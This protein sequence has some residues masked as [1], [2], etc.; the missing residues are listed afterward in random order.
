MSTAYE[1]L[2]EGVLEAGIQVDAIGLQSHMHQGYWGE[3]KT[4]RHP[5]P[6]RA[7]RAAAAP[8][9][10]DAAVRATSCPRTSRTSTTTRSPRGRRRPRARRGRPTRS[11]GTTGPC[12]GHPAVQA[13]TYWGITD[14]GAWLG[15]PAG[16]VRADGTPKPA[17]DALR[18]LVKD[19]WWLPPTTLRTSSTGRVPVSGFRGTYSRGRGAVRA[20][21]RR[22]GRRPAGRMTG[23]PSPPSSPSPTPPTSASPTTSRLTDV[24]LR[25]R[26]EPAEGLYIAESSTVISARARGRPPAAVGAAVPRW[27]PDLE[28]LLAGLPADDTVV[29]VY[30]AEERR[31]RGD[32]RVPPA[33]RGARRDAPAGAASRSPGA[34]RRRTAAGRRPGG[35]R[36]P[37]QRRRRL[38]LRGRARAS[39][40]CSSPRAAPTRSTGG[41]SGSRWGPCSR[42]RGRGIDPWPDGIDVLRE[43]GLHR[44]ALALSDDSITLDDLVAD[45]P[46]RLALVLGA[47]GHGLKPA[48]VGRVRPGGADPDGR[49]G[50]L[51]QRRRGRAVAFW[52]TPA[53]P[54]SGARRV[55][56]G[57]RVAQEA[58][59][60]RPRSPCGRAGEH[61]VAAEP[62]HDPGTRTLAGVRR[63]VV[64]RSGARRSRGR[65]SPT[66]TGGR[67]GGR[68]RPGG[69][70]GVPHLVVA[71]RPRAGPRRGCARPGC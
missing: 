9:R 3:E 44:A 46:D 24:A 65:R 21:A 39:T 43:A 27:L 23:C 38:P 66:G 12:V 40:P 37:H 4:L 53:C 52:A 8:D 1:C 33:P 6:V 54:G 17:Y 29:P 62:E 71:P 13:A 57:Q 10:D 18:R 51:A 48:T 49:R 2:I 58:E 32:H 41:R 7:L 19:E 60:P 34:A 15:A 42:C 25:S 64:R 22:G 16:L 59:G 45:P 63:P 61:R 20:G 14:E 11:S 28:R 26:Q 50:G 31:A 69:S 30:V 56:A 68:R 35:H 47:E 36:R 5:R 55:V 70:G 67:P